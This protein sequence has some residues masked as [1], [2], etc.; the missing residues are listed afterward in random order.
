M[1]RTLVHC[2][3]L[4]LI[5]TREPKIIFRNLYFFRSIKALRRALIDTDQAQ[6]ECELEVMASIE[7]IMLI[8]F[9]KHAQLKPVLKLLHALE[10]RSAGTPF[11]EQMEAKLNYIGEKFLFLSSS[12]GEPVF[13]VVSRRPSS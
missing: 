7:M 4:V 8:A 9:T 13:L 10:Q 5:L 1:G 6:N 3:C 2:V 11:L 12:S